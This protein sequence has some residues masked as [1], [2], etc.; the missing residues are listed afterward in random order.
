MIRLTN[1][2]DYAIVLACE[3]AQTDERKSAQDLS[4]STKFPVPTVA[5]IL[6]ALS[7][8][9][10]LDSKRGLKGGFT[11]ARSPAEISVS[12]IVEAIDGPIALTACAGAGTN[13]CSYD[14]FC[15]MR[16]KWQVINRAVRLALDNVK[17]SAIS[18][19]VSDDDLVALLR[20]E[21]LPHASK[22]N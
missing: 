11:L 13:D 6:N 15:M 18:G 4:V 1:L 8:A 5:K 9:E 10:L 20:G 12:D 14:D 21:A 22:S 17:L 7:R 2:A 19:P 16:P 3:L